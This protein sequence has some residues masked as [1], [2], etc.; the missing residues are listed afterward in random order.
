MDLRGSGISNNDAKFLTER[1]MVELQMLGLYEILERE[2]MD[3]ILKEQGF[4]QSGACDE[5]SCLVEAGKL[6]PVE[7][8]I[9]GS[10]GKFGETYSI[11][12]RLIDIKTGMVNRSACRDFTQKI[13]FLLTQGMRQVA[14]D[15]SGVAKDSEAKSLGAPADND[16]SYA[17][18]IKVIEYPSKNKYEKLLK[19][20]Q[21]GH[22]VINKGSKQG[23]SKGLKLIIKRFNSEKSII[24]PIDKVMLK[25]VIDDIA[26]IQISKVE[27]SYSECIIK[28]TFMPIMVG[29]KVYLKP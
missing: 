2:K 26:E 20:Q 28:K 4:Q 10:V 24:D 14:M 1:L 18:V 21:I 8:I 25:P 15:I 23:A 16:S 29:D 3:D 5:T 19:E 17:Y 12:I 13:D 27:E 22:L 7:K 11:V 9:G 6:L